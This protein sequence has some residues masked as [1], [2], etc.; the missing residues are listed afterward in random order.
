M[1]ERVCGTALRAAFALL[2][3]GGQLAACGGS[4][5]PATQV[6]QGRTLTAARVVVQP[7][8]DVDV[9]VDQG[10]V[11]FVLDNAGLLKMTLTVASHASGR[12]TVTM[13]ATLLDDAGRQVG[14]AIGGDVGVDA[15]A[16]RRVELNGP[17]PT[18]TIARV[19][20]AIS[21]QAA[22]G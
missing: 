17:A 14:S 18:G 10:S 12:S 15:G 5:Q 21:A 8:G 20:L 11:T 2:A 6:D 1:W 7:Q 9:T 19:D 13:K 4:E 3:A 22:P 16:H